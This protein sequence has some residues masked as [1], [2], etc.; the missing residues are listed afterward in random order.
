M[1]IKKSKITLGEQTIL[2]GSIG[3]NIANV[4]IVEELI[5]EAKVETTLMDLWDLLKKKNKGQ[6]DVLLNNGYSN[7]FFIRHTFGAL[8]IVQA[9]WIDEG[10]YLMYHSINNLGDCIPDY[11][12]CVFCRNS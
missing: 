11:G 9:R 7:V 4:S 3:K 8:R 10:W 12:D 1:K 5:Y 6:E 2:Y